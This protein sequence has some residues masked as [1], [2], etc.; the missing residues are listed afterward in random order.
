MAALL[1]AI[2]VVLFRG[3]VGR[4]EAIDCVLRFS[5]MLNLNLLVVL[6]INNVWYGCLVET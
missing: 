1:T 3:F 5:S 2:F 6:V 4:Y